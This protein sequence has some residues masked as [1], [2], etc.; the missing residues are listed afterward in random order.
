MLVGGHPEADDA[1]PVEIDHDALDGGDHC[2]AGQRIL[3]GLELRVPDLG[4]D[5]VHFAD[6][7]LVLLEG[8]D[9]LGVGRP[10]QDGTF[11]PGPA[12]V[13]GG[14]AEILHAVGGELGFAIGGEVADPE[15]VIAEEGV[16]FAIGGADVDAA[17]SAASAAAASPASTAAG[18]GGTGFG[19][20]LCAGEIA[21]VAS[22]GLDDDGLPVGRELDGLERKVPGVD[23]PARGGGERGGQLRVIESGR[24][25]AFGGI[26]Q[27][28]FGAVSGR[29]AVPESL[30]GQPVRAD[31]GAV[32]E[33]GRV[34]PHELLG[35]LVFGGRELLLRGQ[36]ERGEND[37]GWETLGVHSG[38]IITL[39]GE[40]CQARAGS[41]FSRRAG[42]LGYTH[43][44]R[45][46]GRRSSAGRASD[47]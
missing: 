47:L 42:A 4:V 23:G 29:D 13:V 35:V 38:R 46:P 15:V 33:R 14:I 25:G 37:G 3:P 12:R 41:G 36:G 40:W 16:L 26:D 45:S 11:G 7:A 6:A 22:R 1:R 17:E 9:A 28:E 32:N 21:A 8:G 27:D 43:G 18:G 39:T 19:G 44:C 5:Q 34:V 24:A 20:A 30:V 2:V 10:E 31:A